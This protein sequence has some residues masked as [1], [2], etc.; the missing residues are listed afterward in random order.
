MNIFV[1]TIANQKLIKKLPF[2][3]INQKKQKMEF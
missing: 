1:L 2:A 3:K